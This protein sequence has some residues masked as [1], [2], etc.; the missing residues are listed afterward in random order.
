MFRFEEFKVCSIQFKLQR[1]YVRF[2]F[3]KCV[4]VNLK[5]FFIFSIWN[6]L[7][8]LI[9]FKFFEKNIVILVKLIRIK[10]KFFL[11]Q[12]IILCFSFLEGQREEEWGFYRC[13]LL[14]WQYQF[15]FLLFFELRIKVGQCRSFLVFLVFL[16]SYFIFEEQ[17]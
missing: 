14:S 7:D 16:L 4:L 15:L 2:D 3:L 10:I 1:I 6:D 9:L 5:F 8:F 17:V 13:F 11:G 12:V